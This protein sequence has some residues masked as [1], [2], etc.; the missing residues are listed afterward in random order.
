MTDECIICLHPKNT[1]INKDN[2]FYSKLHGLSFIFKCNCVM[3][4]HNECMTTWIETNPVCPYCRNNLDIYI[5][6]N[7]RMF[8]MSKR[9]FNIRVMRLITN[10]FYFWALI[11]FLYLYVF[12]Y[13]DPNSGRRINEFM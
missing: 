7:T 3:K 2:V 6:W 12:I 11:R 8:L 10:V 4:C 13:T 9:I 1:K 5:T